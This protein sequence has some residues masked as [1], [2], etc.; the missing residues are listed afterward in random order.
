MVILDIKL[1]GKLVAY[2]S[3]QLERWLISL[4]LARLADLAARQ[5]DCRWQW[6]YFVLV[7]EIS[8]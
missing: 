8:E 2:L 6:F 4:R 1:I 7:A 3:K 5:V